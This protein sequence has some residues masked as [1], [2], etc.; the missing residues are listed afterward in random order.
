MQ[1]ALYCA[2]L[3]AVAVPLGAYMAKIYAGVPGVL[4]AIERPIFRL[5]GIDPH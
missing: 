4:V 2:V 5:A 3:I 1:F